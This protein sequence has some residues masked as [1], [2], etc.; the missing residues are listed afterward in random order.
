MALRSVV[1]VYL[2]FAMYWLMVVSSILKSSELTQFYCLFFRC[3]SCPS[4]YLVS[5]VM[6][7]GV[8]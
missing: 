2:L 3:R 8:I 4:S 5:K 6:C 1:K 7:L